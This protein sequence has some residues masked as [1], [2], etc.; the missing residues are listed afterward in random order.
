MNLNG[1]SNYINS[2][3]IIK[4]NNVSTKSFYNLGCGPSNKDW[5]ECR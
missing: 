3:S 5:E 2:S 4:R 1:T